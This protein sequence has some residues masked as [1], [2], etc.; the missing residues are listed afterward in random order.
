MSDDIL[1]SE[2]LADQIMRWDWRDHLRNGHF[3][4]IKGMF[5]AY[6]KQESKIAIRL[7]CECGHLGSDGHLEPNRQLK[8]DDGLYASA[9]KS[10]HPTDVGECM[11]MLSKYKYKCYGFPHV[12][13]SHNTQSDNWSVIFRNP[14]NFANPG[15]KSATP[16]EACHLM[17]DFIKTL[18]IYED[19]GN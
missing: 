4:A 19:D 8:I 1:K 17:L 12:F 16:I 3:I 6:A 14:V 10:E 15:F 11:I 5:D 7:Y 13:L 18:P 2:E 9:L